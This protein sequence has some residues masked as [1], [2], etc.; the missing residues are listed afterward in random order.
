[1][2]ANERSAKSICGLLKFGKKLHIE[3]LR[4]EGLLHMKP[5]SYFIGLESGAARSDSYEGTSY[6]H[7]P[8]HIGKFTIDSPLAGKIDVDTSELTDS[9]RISLNKTSSCNI[10]CMVAITQPVDGLLVE[11]SIPEFGDSFVLILNPTEF[12]SRV[13]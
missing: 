13:S 2:V 4:S 1:M 12:L 5:I 3:Q 10:Y 9:V 7:Q 11:K 6:I 8:K